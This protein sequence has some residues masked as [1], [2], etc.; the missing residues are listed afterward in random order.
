MMTSS[1]NKLNVVKYLNCEILVLA[2]Y[3]LHF[4]RS[5]S[6]THLA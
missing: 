5:A 4:A 6:S 2:S 1:R 3:N